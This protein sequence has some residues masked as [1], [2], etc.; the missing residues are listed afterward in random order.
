MASTETALQQN[1]NSLDYQNYI[2][3]ESFADYLIVYA[4]ANNSEPEHPKS[5]YM[6]KDGE[7]KLIA[8]PVWDFDYSTFKIEKTG[9]TNRYSPVFKHLIRKNAFKTILAE[10]WDTYKPEFEGIFSFIDSLANYTAKA[11]ERNI[12][13][14]PI[15]IEWNKIGDEE[16][17]FNESVD[18]LKNCIRKKI[19]E[20]DTL[21]R[22]L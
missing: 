19:D 13:L 14:W 12:K 2:D 17:T 16:K 21:I 20:L 9:F 15:K 8:G 4:M 1:A 5:V 6:H 10:R 22:K 11:N 3:Q 7:G 18:M